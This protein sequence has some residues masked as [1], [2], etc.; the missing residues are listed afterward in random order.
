MVRDEILA[1]SIP[2]VEQPIYGIGIWKVTLDG[3]RVCLLSNA[4]I[5]VCGSIPLLSANKL[6]DV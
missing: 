5:R 1:N 3:D 4:Y 2:K 6:R